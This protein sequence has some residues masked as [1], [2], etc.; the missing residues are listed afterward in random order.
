MALTFASGSLTLVN[1]EFGVGDIAALAGAGRNV[2]NW[3]M[4]QTRDRNLV[5]FLKVDIDTI[6]T[7]KGFIDVVELH[8][9]WDRKLTLFQNGRPNTLEH[10]GGNHFR[11]PCLQEQTVAKAC[12][13]QAGY[14]SMS[15]I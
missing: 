12:K 7:R 3:V 6:I 5:D 1:W 14:P 15:Y 9:R 2:G 8:K 4:A 13:S 11:L 10:P